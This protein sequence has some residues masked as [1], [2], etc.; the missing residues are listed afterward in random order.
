[1]T[2]S[3]PATRLAGAIAAA[4]SSA[5]PNPLD[6]GRR[7]QDVGG[8]PPS[9]DHL[10]QVADRRAARAG[11]DHDPAGNQGGGTLPL[12]VEGSPR[13]RAEPP[14]GGMPAR[15]LRS[16]WARSCGC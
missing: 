4:T 13:P 8:P 7:D 6:L 12:G 3:A 1:M 14:S 11:D 9:A 2:R 16:L 5:A 15:V 10:E